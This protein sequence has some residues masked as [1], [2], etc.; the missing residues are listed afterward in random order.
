MFSDRPPVVVAER[1]RTRDHPSG[2]DHKELL[3]WRPELRVRAVEHTLEHL[4]DARLPHR[5]HEWW[6]VELLRLRDSLVHK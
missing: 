3:G 1:E 6:V 5:Q 4:R 2:L